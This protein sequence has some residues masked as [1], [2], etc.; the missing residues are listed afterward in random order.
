MHTDLV[1]QRINN[2]KR[3]EGEDKPHGIGDF[4]ETTFSYRLLADHTDV[5]ENPQD[6]AGTEFVEGLDVKR[7][8]GRIQFATDEEVVD[9]VARVTTKSK[10]LAILVRHGVDGGGLENR[11]ED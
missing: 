7:P 1:V 4:G 9:E 6:E 3:L 10:E 2:V 8:D 11:H 5:N